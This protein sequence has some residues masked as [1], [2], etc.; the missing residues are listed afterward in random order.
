MSSN[1]SI[2]IDEGERHE[3]YVRHIFKDISSGP[4]STFN[5]FIERTN[6]DC[7]IGREVPAG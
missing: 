1:Y 3:D 4:N 7:Y 6:G 5:C 2:V